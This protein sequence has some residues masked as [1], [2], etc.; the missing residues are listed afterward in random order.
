MG[1]LKKEYNNIIEQF[2]NFTNEA[3]MIVSTT[4]TIKHF[5]HPAEQ[6]LGWNS[7]EIVGNKLSLMLVPERYRAKHD[8]GFKEFTKHNQTEWN[9]V[10]TGLHHE[11]FEIQLELTVFRVAKHK[12]YVVFLRIPTMDNRKTDEKTL[13]FANMSHEI[14]TPLNGII[15]MSNLLEDTKLDEEQKEYLNIIRQSSYTLMAI[16]NDILDITKLDS[17]KV[18][19]VIKPFSLRECIENSCDIVK[20]KAQEKSL[21]LV[22]H[23]DNILPTMITGDLNRLQQILINLVSNAIK[24][25]D[26]GSV[27]IMVSG[28]LIN[29]NDDDAASEN[30][31]NT[32]KIQFDITDTGIGIRQS[33][34]DK[35]F[36]T[37]TQIDQSET[38]NYPG[39]GLGLAISKRLVTLM[40]GT[41]WFDSVF[42]QG[43]TFHF[44]IIATEFEN[45]NTNI[46]EFKVIL[47]DKKI[48]IVDDNQT[49]RIMLNSQLLKWNMFP[50]SCS[51]AEEALIYIRQGRRFDMALIDIVMPTM[52][53]N[54]LVEKF[55][56][57][58]INFPIIALSSGGDGITINEHFDAR[59]V[60]PIKEQKLL[61]TILNLFHYNV[62]KYNMYSINNNNNDHQNVHRSNYRNE[63]PIRIIVAEDVY[64][65]QRVIISLLYKLGYTNVTIVSN[66]LELLKKME[67]QKYDLLLLDL[68][69]PHMDGLTASKKIHII[70]EPHERPYIVALTASAMAG[71]KEYY[72]NE[73][74]MDDYMTK[75]IE[76]SEL[77]RVLDAC[78]R[79]KF[80]SKSTKVI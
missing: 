52:S 21:D 41:I 34:Y 17:G 75:P 54:D 79:N 18:N 14:R 42:G 61:N 2:V 30:K 40:G 13:F 26:T 45:I 32:W 46:D 55:I 23:I 22:Y 77:I 72:I 9:Q 36:K 65:N 1:S 20:L 27:S 64:M 3:T 74:A 39:T 70:Y 19:I 68:K 38:K 12:K 24:F 28:E 57:M 73:G 51:S 48:L 31:N 49:N 7:E 37:F 33:D 8:K 59:I 43:S 47:K 69:M 4:G 63:H 60:K 50:I 56:E 62:P 11:G 10:V 6:L 76:R 67:E 25:T 78:I 71:D 15:G 53:G 16:I 58:G 66:G 5:N 35:L 80:V 29:D 44:T